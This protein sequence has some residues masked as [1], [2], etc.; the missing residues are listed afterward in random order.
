MS[1]SKSLAEIL[2]KD[3][4]STRLIT[5]PGET[6]ALQVA[7]MM[8]QGN[9]GAVF[10]KKDEAPVSIITDR[11]YAIKIAVNQNDLSI[12]VE[13]IASSP[14]ITVS[15]N[16]TI[17]SASKVMQEKK[18]RKLAVKDDGKIVGIITSTNIV[19]KVSEY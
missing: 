10:I 18:I 12:P 14:L 1:Q 7:K 19:N 2:V 15:P 11:D 3:V 13:K 4:M 9:I 17:V 16:D 8:E 6:T 5:V